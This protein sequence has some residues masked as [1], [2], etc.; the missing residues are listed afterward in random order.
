MNS[1]EQ[2]HSER[3]HLIKYSIGLAMREAGFPVSTQ[4]V[5]RRTFVQATEAVW[6]WTGPVGGLLGSSCLSLMPKYAILCD[7]K[8]EWHSSIS[9][10]D[11]PGRSLRVL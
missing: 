4:K 7:C 5:S 6:T 3:N 8:W 1:R 10:I 9:S 11:F 2:E